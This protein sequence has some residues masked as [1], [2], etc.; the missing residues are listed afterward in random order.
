ME[1]VKVIIQK[2]EHAKEN[3][4]DEAALLTINDLLELDPNNSHYLKEKYLLSRKL[5]IELDIGFIRKLCWYRSTDGECF[6][7]L[8]QKYN[9]QNE[10]YSALLATAYSLSVE[11]NY[12][13]R[14]LLEQIL[15]ELGF[16]S[17]AIYIMKTNRIGHLTCEPDSWLRQQATVD[18]YESNELHLFICNGEISNLAFFE[19]LK[20]YMTIIESDFFH[21]LHRSRPQLLSDEFY[22]KCLMIS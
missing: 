7:C 4:N 2:F 19:I 8:A 1:K 9:A 14:E 11:E 13:A 3:K 5:N 16:S 6:Y 15:G 17:L 18:A 12:H 10:Q 22:R 20:R 21:R